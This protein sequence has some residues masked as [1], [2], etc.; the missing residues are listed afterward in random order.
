MGIRN[1]IGGCILGGI[2]SL[3]LAAAGSDLADA[4]MNKDSAAVRSLLTQKADANVAQADGATALHWAVKWDDVATVDLLLKAGANA[5][6]ANRVGATPMYLAC[7]NGNA[8]IIEKLIA[9]GVDVNAPLLSSKETA[10]MVAARTGKPDAVKVLL[11]HGA[12]ANAKE[13][14]RGTTAMMWAA[15][16]GHAE[17]IRLLASRGGDVSAA[18][19]VSIPTQRRGN[20]DDDQDEG[21]I[22]IGGLTALVFAAREGSMD[23]VQ[24]LLDVK[25]DVNQ[26]AADGTSPLEVAVLNGNYDIAVFLMDKGASP[27]I[28]N[29]KGWTPLYQAVKN[30]NLEVGAVPLMKTGALT[31]ELELI[32]IILNH[33]ADPNIRARANFQGRNGQG[34]T[35]MKEAGA[36]PFLRAS[37]NGDITVMRL[38][39]NYGADPNI[40]TEDHTTP[41]MALSGVGFAEGFISHHS[42]EET[43][44]ALRLVLELGADVNAANDRGLTALHGAAHRGDNQVIQV[45]ADL[46]AQLNRKDH[47]PAADNHDDSGLTPL[48][49]AIGVRISAAS[50]IYKEDTV[51]LLTKLMKE[52][53][54]AL[55]ETALK[56]IG[57]KRSAAATGA[58]Q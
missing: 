58:K 40:P 2:F 13:S 45:L 8:A 10:I 48:D 35:W 28:T 42:P 24:A 50:P 1:L 43:M 12:Q 37:L 56:T 16:Q 22:P 30:R 17:V 14:L 34:G 55:P 29:R 33:G 20:D 46:G 18:S 19:S 7:V 32:K 52:H 49:W 57:G 25:A 21:G 26:T 47:S 31:D 38:L 27:N 6:A 39:L 41:L 15:E 44:Q 9:A 54:V 23:A 5:K 53:G 11:D 4:A 51:E 36:T 3:S